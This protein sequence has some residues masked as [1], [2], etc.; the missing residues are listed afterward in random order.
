VRKC[1]RTNLRLYWMSAIKPEPLN[2]L[3]AP[4]NWSV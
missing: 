4:A 2:I 1:L 3:L